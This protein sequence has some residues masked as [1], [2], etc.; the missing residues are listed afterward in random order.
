[1]LSTSTENTTELAVVAQTYGLPPSALGGPG[2]R[3]PDAMIAPWA[4]E[5][6]SILVRKSFDLRAV[7]RAD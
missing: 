3:G 4:W 5:T 7:A 2:P 6:D 1:M